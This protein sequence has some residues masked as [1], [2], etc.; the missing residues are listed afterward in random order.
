MREYCY[1]VYLGFQPQFFF[2]DI[3]VTAIKYPNIEIS[4]YQITDIKSANRKI[5][6]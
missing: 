3:T 5:L 4:N 6:R 2:Q 1:K